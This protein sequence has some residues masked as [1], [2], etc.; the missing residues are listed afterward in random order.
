M[1]NRCSHCGDLG[2]NRSTCDMLQIQLESAAKA[3]G[4]YAI[5][6][7]KTRGKG[8]KKKNRT[9]SFCQT[10]GHDRRTCNNISDFIEIDSQLTLEARLIYKDRVEAQ[11]FGVGALVEFS[12]SDYNLE[13]NDYEKKNF[14]G[15]VDQVEWSAI[16]HRIHTNAIRVVRVAYFGDSNP[17]KGVGTRTQK[18]RYMCLPRAILEGLSSDDGQRFPARRAHMHSVR[19]L[20]PI[21][22]VKVPENF[23]SEPAI[24]KK[25]REYTRDLT[26]WD[27]TIRETLK[28]SRD[29]KKEAE[30]S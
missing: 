23:I 20:V 12:T 29:T 9:C 17:K 16:D 2:H 27:Y 7:L 6:A 10:K 21:D 13:T 25:S 11:G 24:A 5:E 30:P 28:N 19:V 3:G 15:V 8:V 14:V 26:E 18:S 1:Q 22:D 4:A